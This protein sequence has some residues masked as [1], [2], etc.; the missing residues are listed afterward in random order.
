MEMEFTYRFEA[1]H[2]F[3][4]A[5]SPKCM[6]PH[7]HTWWTRLNFRATGSSL[8]SNAM[9]AEFASV[10]TPWKAFIDNVAD[11]SFF[12]HIQDPLAFH[13]KK[14]IPGF[15]GLPFPE[16]PTTEL[17]SIL[18]LEKAKQIVAEIKEQKGLE[19]EVESIE[20]QETPTNKISVSVDSQMFMNTIAKLNP[21]WQAWWQNPNVEDRNL[22]ST[23]S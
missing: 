10:K 23:R 5:S 7:G 20:I 16:D 1:A 3:M 22:N 18:F 6:T 19:I 11:H 12:H 9:I 17:I 21:E 2:R 13:S 15:R 8:N 14:E 4:G